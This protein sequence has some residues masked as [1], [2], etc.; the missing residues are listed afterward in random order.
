MGLYAHSV[1]D[2]PSID[3]FIEEQY[4]FLNGFLDNFDHYTHGP[5]REMVVVTW[6]SKLPSLVSSQT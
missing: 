3:V 2:L 1:N 4:L 6:G 5:I